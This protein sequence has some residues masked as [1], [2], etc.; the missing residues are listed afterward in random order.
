M[1]DAESVY[2]RRGAARVGRAL[3]DLDILWFE[4]PLS[5]RDIPGHRQLTRT[6]STPVVPAG[7]LI[8]DPRELASVLRSDP[9]SAV[10]TQ[11]MEGGVGHVT[12]MAAVARA[13]GLDVELCSYGTTLTQ[14]IDLHLILGLGLGHYYEQPFPTE[15][16]EFGTTTAGRRPGRRGAR[17]HRSRP[18]HGAGPGGDRRR[19]ARPF[20]HG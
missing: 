2:D 7:G 12:D 8:D 17:P 18:R 15:P 10:R 6:L 20:Q 11:T 1:V 13:F 5:D 14:V 9:W 3:D 16:W 19:D 4:A